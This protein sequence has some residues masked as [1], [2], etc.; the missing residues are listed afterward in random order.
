M[1]WAFVAFGIAVLA[2]GV[3]GWIVVGHWADIR[4]LDP[5]SIKEERLKQER[6]KVI[7]R[8]FERA[9]AD[10]AASLQRLGRTLVK[11]T[12]D[13]YRKTYQRI[14]AMD[15]VYRKVK[16]P[17]AAMAPSQREKVAA[18]LSEARSLMRDL[19]WADAER[20]FLEVL[21]IDQRN[22][23]AYKGLGTIYLKQKLYPQARETYEFLVKTKKADD[24]TYSGLAEIAEA[25]GNLSSAESMRLKAVEA[26]PKQP[27]RHAEL[28][29][30]YLAHDRPERA[31]EPA[32]RASDLEPG[33]AKYLELS[34]EVAILLGDRNEAKTRWNR[35]RLLSDDPSRFQVLKDKV[36]AL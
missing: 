4:L 34:L 29:H 20:R 1:I 33:S 7:N 10:Q 2:F 17:F 3:M 25:E 18:F 8:R 24:S 15:R 5:M 31:W 21:S 30:F 12:R 19:K 14:A 13:S 11:K 27:H 35:L 36:D 32:K 26:S 16:S 23:D 9:S 22:I 6:G 28:A